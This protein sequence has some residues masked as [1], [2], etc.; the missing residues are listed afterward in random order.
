MFTSGYFDSPRSIAS[1][2][3]HVRTSSWLLC[4]ASHTDR[5]QSSIVAARP[6]SRAAITSTAVIFPRCS[7]NGNSGNSLRP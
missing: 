4:H 6:C 1:A 3:A 5:H 2:L 7:G